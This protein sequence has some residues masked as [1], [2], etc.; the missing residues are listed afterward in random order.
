MTNQYKARPFLSPS[1]LHPSIINHSSSPCRTGTILFEKK[2]S[3]TKRIQQCCADSWIIALASALQVCPLFQ[4]RCA[5]RIID[6]VQIWPFEALHRCTLFSAYSAIL[7]AIN[8]LPSFNAA[9]WHRPWNLLPKISRTA[10]NSE[11]LEPQPKLLHYKPFC[12]AN[13]LTAAYFAQADDLSWSL[14][15]PSSTIIDIG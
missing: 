3:C 4:R 7:S 5:D 14:S 12:P 13:C 1:P 11:K 8:S 9:H 10:G 15:Y 6:F 2:T